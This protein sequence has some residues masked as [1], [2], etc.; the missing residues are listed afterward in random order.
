MIHRPPTHLTNYWFRNSAYY[1][2][3]GAHSLYPPPPHLRCA[4]AGWQRRF[5]V[6]VRKSV[7]SG[8][9]GVRE[10][11]GL[12]GGGGESHKVG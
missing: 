9:V 7:S 1:K 12:G 10:E 6:Q 3:Q 5:Q 11:G 2:T 4:E 8:G